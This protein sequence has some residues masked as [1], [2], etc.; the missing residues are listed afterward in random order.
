M[1]AAL[2]EAQAK[3]AHAQ[4]HARFQ[5]NKSRR[6]ESYEVGDYALLAKH[7]TC[8]STSIFQ[9]SYVNSGSVLLGLLR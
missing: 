4:S 9:Q 7:A 5:V 2:E 1:K 6:K 3:L 8:V